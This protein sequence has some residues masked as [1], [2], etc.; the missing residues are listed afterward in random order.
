MSSELSDSED[1]ISSEYN[2]GT[3]SFESNTP[4]QLDP[5]VDPYRYNYIVYKTRI[6]YRYCTSDLTLLVHAIGQVRYRTTWVMNLRQEKKYLPAWTKIYAI[7][8]GVRC[9]C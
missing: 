6:A 4:G 5:K 7:V 9:L 2:S 3:S 8:K 1:Y